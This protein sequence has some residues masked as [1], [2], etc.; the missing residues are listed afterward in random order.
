MAK[1]EWGIKRTC[2][3]CG[4]RFYDLGKSPIVCP[5]CGTGFDPQALLRP[6]RSR[7]APVVAPTPAKPVLEDIEIDDEVIEDADIEGA[8]D[9]DEEIIEDASELGEDKDDM[10]EVIESVEEEER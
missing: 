8:D 3:G 10:F 4:A 9:D 7:P 5:K 1:R 2:Q 6:Q